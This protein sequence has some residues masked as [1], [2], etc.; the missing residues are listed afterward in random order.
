MKP[1]DDQAL[2]NPEFWDERYSKSDGTAPTHEWFRSFADLEPFLQKNVFSVSGM[3]PEDNPAI[4]HLGSGDSVRGSCPKSH[5]AVHFAE[6]ARPY[7][8]Y[9]SI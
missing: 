5:C 7:R 1:E 8:P 2:S 6:Q 9:Q 4:L 3:K